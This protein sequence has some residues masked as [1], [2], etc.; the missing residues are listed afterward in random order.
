VAADLQGQTV[1]VTGGSR[2]LGLA[3]SKRLLAE[4]ANLSLWDLDHEG[5]QR[6]KD[7]L[8]AGERVHAVTADVTSE[9]SVG[10]A[11]D[12]T[13]E[14]F[15]GIAVLVNNAGISGP[16]AV[17]WKLSLD[18]WQQVIGVNTTGVFLCCK[19]VVPAMLA[20]NYGRIINIASVAGKEASPSISA[21]ATSKAGVIGFT[22][23]L[24]RELADSNVTVNCVTPA[25]IKTAIFDKWPIDYVEGLRAK[26]PMGRFGTPEELAALVAWIASREASFSTGAVFDLSGGR[27]DY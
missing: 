19:A 21:Y 12:S 18:D 27:T 13:L 16:H 3:I 23:T 20:A 10:K 8:G 1:V 26:I 14:K 15:G 22:K 24:G 11:R 17:A 5:L 2:G 7:A 25:A 4:G 9:A 6:A